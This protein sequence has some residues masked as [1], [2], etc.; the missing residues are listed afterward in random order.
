MR[1]KRR[2]A[3]PNQLISRYGTARFYAKPRAQ[4]EWKNPRVPEWKP[5]WM[6]RFHVGGETWEESAGPLYPV[7]DG[8]AAVK[9]WAETM[10]QTRLEAM[11]AGKLAELQ[12]VVRAADDVMLS[13]VRRVYLQNVP[14][15]KPDYRKNISRLCSILTE[16]T[17]LD[18]ER[19]PVRD[20]LW[21]RELFL[22]W[23]RMRQEHFRRGWSMKNAAPLDAWTEL[24]EALKAGKLPGIDKDTPMECN[25]TIQT[26]FRCAKAVFANSREYLVGLK[27]PDLREF[28]AFSVDVEAPKGHRGLDEAVQTA[29]AENVGRLA[30]EMPK[31]HAFYLVATWTGARPVT[32]KSLPGAALRLLPSG[33][34]EIDLPAAKGG[35]GVC[36]RVDAEAAR[37]LEA[38]RTPLSLIGASSRTEADHIYRAHNEW[39]TSQGVSGTLKSY[40]L[41]H[42]R[43]QQY[44]EH[45]GLELAAAGGGHTTT[46]MVERRY[47]QGAKT[48]PLVSPFQK[49]G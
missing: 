45:G 39:L 43:L 44:R 4:S 25:T 6:V 7:A 40:Q 19:V 31:V 41:R 3:D 49:A 20:A 23:V 36:V 34:G 12:A 35:R 18:V 2:A 24:R 9:Q 8:L 21:S 29:L 37:A 30:V 42:R 17:G 13:E 46:A 38:V 11:R 14:P 47:T 48:I 22:G 32:I 27:L 28:L 15:G 5:N 26:Y 1:T 16:A 10:M 33:E